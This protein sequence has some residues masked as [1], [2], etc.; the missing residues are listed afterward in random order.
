MINKAQQMDGETYCIPWL[1]DP[2]NSQA[3]YVAGN[4]L[5]SNCNMLES[6][7]TSTPSSSATFGSQTTGYL[8]FAELSGKAALMTTR[9]AKCNPHAAAEAGANCRLLV[10]IRQALVQ[11]AAAVL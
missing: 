8:R 3:A 7:D 1:V 6:W 9:S 10:C 11:P 4:G 2:G 5:Y